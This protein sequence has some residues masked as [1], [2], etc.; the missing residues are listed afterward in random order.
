MKHALR[1]HVTL[2]PLAFA[3]LLVALPA[4][5]PASPRQVVSFEAPREL[6]SFNDRD[7]TLDQIRGF[8]VTNVRQLVY[9]RD[10]APKPN[11]KHKPRFD[12][13]APSSYP[14]GNWD[15]LDQ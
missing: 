4:A 2:L 7:R 11:A 8:G 5:A 10:F 9:W 6:L 15:R 1:R 13:A 3:I 12:A 14:A